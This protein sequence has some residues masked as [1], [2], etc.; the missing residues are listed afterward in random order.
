VRP[1]L[2]DSGAWIALLNR[3]DRNHES[4]RRYHRSLVERGRLLLTTNYVIAESATRLRHDAGLDVALKLREAIRRMVAAR[5]LRV[6]WIDP[7]LE[8]EGWDLMARHADLRLSLADATSASLARR[9]GR[10]RPSR[11]TPTSGRSGSRCIPGRSGRPGRSARVCGAE[12]LRKYS[13]SPTGATEAGA[14]APTRREDERPC[15]SSS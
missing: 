1:V 4:A 9:A 15:P 13:L 8:G 6:A 10:G 12:R 5:E 2:I 14:P 3:A 7:R 11:S